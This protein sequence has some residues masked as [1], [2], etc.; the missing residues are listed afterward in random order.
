VG[1]PVLATQALA[2][3]PSPSFD[4]PAGTLGHALGILSQEARTNIGTSDPD[5][6]MV[7]VPAIHG[8]HSVTATLD[9]LLAGSGAVASRT[10]SGGWHVAWRPVQAASHAVAMTDVAS[11]IV[12]TG[13]K[14]STPLT[15][16]P[17]SVFILSGDALAPAGALP[18]SNALADRLTSVAS[19]HFG[20]GRDK[21]FIRGMADT[22]FTGPSQSTTGQYL[23][24]T[25]L[26][27]NAPDPDLR[28][29]DVASIE[30]LEGPQGTLYG[31][32]SLGGVVRVVTVR[33]QIGAFTAS[34]AGGVSTTA[35]GDADGDLSAVV[36]VPL[37]GSAALRLVGYGIR[38]GGYIDNPM[39]GR[40]NING[41]T[42]VGG[43]AG[44]RIDLGNWTVDLGT[45][46]QSIH[47]DDAQWTDGGLPKL[48]RASPERLPYSSDYAL[49]DLTIAR[50]WDG[51]RLVSSTGF[52][53]QAL[54]E[55]YDA[56]SGGLATM[57]RQHDRTSML[58][59]ETR[60]SRRGIDGAEWVL[61]LSLLDN[62]SLLGRIGADGDGGT[63][64]R[65]RATNHVSEATLFGEA[66]FPILA[67]MVATA[68]LRLTA[69]RVHGD[70]DA[71]IEASTIPIFGS[72]IGGRG[73]HVETHALPS[74]GLS[75]Q[76]MSGWLLFARYQRGFRPGGFG[77]SSA[78]ARRFEGDH[79]GTVEIG[80]RFRRPGS[81]VD[82]SLSLAH[83]QWRHIL[84]E[85]VTQGGDPVTENIGDGHIDAIE[86][87]MGWRPTN[88]L[89]FNGGAFLNYSRLTNADFESVVVTGSALPNVARVGVQAGIDFDVALSDTLR[90]TASANARYY[91]GSHVGAGPVLDAAQGRYVDDLVSVRVG[92][93]RRGI[94]V[95]A[96]NLQDSTANRFA[97]GTP[98]LIFSSQATPPRP[99]TIRLRFDSRF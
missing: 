62:R 57:V 56:T 1:L 10:P 86:A 61:G 92:S 81:R 60:L 77:I 26:T 36:N 71:Y 82:L 48:T 79:V 55:R 51:L 85:V 96:T 64:P 72:P 25:R 95:E 18:D 42:T 7:N 32:G 52:T 40:S 28:L 58:A 11:T 16:Y 22:G 87:T 46:I 47:G 29:Y 88:R 8:A 94:S 4:L 20:A 76:I 37:A 99:R 91:G 39:L 27:Y 12:V 83:T 98:Y 24:D 31:A 66:G 44:L 65:E 19:T 97:Y 59:N 50:E 33:P 15:L 6:A 38:D 49:A 43:R 68:G 23:D 74:L 45:T 2:R 9:R 93:G 13:S 41:V 75:Y 89:R 5:L 67:G 34:A 70:A 35:H 84:A 54:V 69:A 80:S 17:G 3:G 78:R 73:T 53:R 30:V 14:R 21:L 63:T 90:L